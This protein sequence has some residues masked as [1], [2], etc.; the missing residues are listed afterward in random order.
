MEFDF[1]DILYQND[2]AYMIKYDKDS[3]GLIAHDQNGA[4]LNGPQIEQ[5]ITGLTNFKNYYR[6]S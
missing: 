5:L 3:N 2:T 4:I 6:V 1:K